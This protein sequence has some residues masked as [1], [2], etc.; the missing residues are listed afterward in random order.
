ME[1]RERRDA[2]AC[3]THFFIV[4][5]DSTVPCAMY[6]CFEQFFGYF[7]GVGTENAPVSHSLHIYISFSYKIEGEILTLDEV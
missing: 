2:K 7:I 5:S 3:V 1:I 6:F 4:V